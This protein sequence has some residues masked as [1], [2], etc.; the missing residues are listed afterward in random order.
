MGEDV[1]MLA[2]LQLT[3]S[4]LDG[5]LGHGYFVATGSDVFAEVGE[6]EVD[7]HDFYLLLVL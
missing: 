2:M 7:L 4:E 5:L 1:D 6:I 3:D